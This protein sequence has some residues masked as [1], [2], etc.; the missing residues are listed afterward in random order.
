MPDIPLFDDW[1]RSITP[2]SPRERVHKIAAQV[3][4]PADLA[5]DYL[6]V[7][8]VESGHRTDVRDSPKGAKGFGQVMPDRPGATTRTVDG[9]RYDLRNPDENV[10]AGLRL[11]QAGG[12]DPV[13]RRLEYFG[14]AGARRQYER[15]GRI[16]NI[17]DGN[18]TAEQY[19]RATGGYSQELTPQ[20]SISRFDDWAKSQQSQPPEQVSP[21]TAK[22]RPTP[23]PS[24]P[25]TRPAYRTPFA[26]APPSQQI[27]IRQGVQDFERP[28]MRSPTG[29]GAILLRQYGQARGIDN[30]QRQRE[31]ATRQQVEQEY[32][33]RRG[34]YGGPTP[35]GILH[36]FANPVDSLLGLARSDEENIARET[37]E[38][39]RQ[40]QVAAQPEVESI[41]RE[42]GQMSAPV[43]SIAAPLIGRG[44][45]GLLKVAGGI[46]SVFGI[47]P[48]RLSDWANKRGEIIE[49]ASALP[50]LADERNLSS[51]VTGETQLKEVERGIPEKVATGLADL[52]VG[53][54]QIILLKRA[55]RLPFNQLLA[56][57]AAAKSSNAPLDQQLGKAAEG[58]ALGTAL[59]SHLGR[60][61]S[62]AL[63]GVPTA[64][65]SGYEVAQGRTSPLDAAIQTGIQAGAGAILGGS[66]RKP[67][68]TQPRMVE[69]TPAERRTAQI[70]ATEADREAIRGELRL[71]ERPHEQAFRERQAAREASSEAPH[72]S[73]RQPRR[74]RGEGKGQFKRGKPVPTEEPIPIEQSNVPAE[75]PALPT[76][77]PATEAVP[78]A[79]E[80]V[81][82]SSLPGESITTPITEVSQPAVTGFTTSQGSAYTVSGQSTQR[83]KTPHVGHDPG[84]IGLKPPSEKT[85]YLDED[86]AREVG[87]WN[88]LNASGKRIAIRGDEVLL[89]S[90]NPKTNQRGLD[91]RFKFTTDPAVGKSPLELRERS[92]S[93]GQR[94]ME[95]YR[96]NHPGTPIR[97]IQRAGQPEAATIRPRPTIPAVTPAPELT[98]EQ[99]LRV[100]HD[101]LSTPEFRE[102]ILGESVGGNAGEG[103]A[104][105]NAAIDKQGKVV[106]LGNIQDFPQ[107]VRDKLDRGEYFPASFI[108]R[109]ALT[110]EPAVERV[111]LPSPTPNQPRQVASDWHVDFEDPSRSTGNAPPEFQEMSRARQS[112][113]APVTETRPRPTA[114]KDAAMQADR[115]ELGLPELE[116]LPRVSAPEVLTE[117]QQRNSANPRATD[118]LVEQAL[119]GKKNFTNVETMQVNLRAQEV[120]NRLNAINDEAF[121]ETDPSRLSDLRAESD[122]LLTEFDRISTAQD[123]AGAEWSRAGTARQRAIAE[124]Y[125]L[126]GLIARAKKVKGRDLTPEE[127][128]HYEQQA[129]R[130]TELE[131]QLN[132]A[133]SRVDDKRFQRE[134]DKLA[135]SRRRGDMREQLDT[136]YA[137]LLTEFKQARA[138]TRNVQAS[139]LAGLDP[140][141]KLTRI[142]LR[143]ARNRVLAGANNAAQLVEGIYNDL[144]DA[145]PGATERDIRDAISGY[146]LTPKTQRSNLQ[147]QLAALKSE[148]QSLSK[149]EDI[150]G[151]IRS[152]RVEGPRLG[153]AIGR[154]EGPQLGPRQGPRPREGW[155]R[156]AEGPRLTETTERKQGPR[157]REGW[158]RIEGPRLSEA[159]GRKEG[160]RQRPEGP[161]K[162]LFTRNETR[163]RQITEQIADLERRIDEQD[164]TPRP[165]QQPLPYTKE[166]Q[167]LEEQLQHTK[168]KFELEM[169]RASPGHWLRQLSG[170]RKSW[171]LSGLS[172]QA[173]NIGGTGAYQIF[174]EV[175]R[176]P[177]VIAD[178]AIAPFTNRRTVTANPVAMLDSVVH[179]ATVGLSEAGQI[180]RKGATREQLERHQF[181]EIDTGVKVIDFTSNLVFRFMSASDRV[182]YQYAHQRNLS[183][184]ARVQ[185]LNEGAG[186]VRARTKELVA[187]PP[188]ELDAAAKHDALVST[189]NNNNLLSNAIKRARAQMGPTANFAIDM[190][191]PFDRTPTNVIARIIEA[192][193]VGAGRAAYGLAKAA[194]TK[195]LTA[196]EQ[197]QFAQTL[198]RATAGTALM[199]LGWTLADKLLDVEKYQVFLNV[200]NQRIDLASISPVGNLLALGARLR[201]DYEKGSVT[202]AV[203]TVGGV[204]LQQPLLKSTTEAV[205]TL[206]DPE[207]SLTRTGARLASSFIPMGGL[208]RDVG[209]LID[210]EERRA[211]TFKEQVQ[212]NVPGLRQRLPV[213][214]RARRRLQ[215]SS[216][217][218]E[219]GARP[220]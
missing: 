212:Q 86:A 117:A 37:Q 154:K 76:A 206:S 49:T 145:L 217:R 79:S 163:A 203:K 91:G 44:G 19:V 168:N 16:P 25:A 75:Q 200:G 214:P 202:G 153:D 158:R 123:K 17:S 192:S 159:Q 143:M 53:L 114:P 57:E 41:R 72:Y 45:G 205:E 61:A 84:D 85:I 138:E 147:A 90:L 162:R 175:A 160:P 140:E 100:N 40:Q 54:G 70:E 128:T 155:K 216:G 13:A 14:G 18:M 69:E 15:T 111:I 219:A 7:A 179:A 116:Q 28:P 68:E 190:V 177:A 204:P 139:G 201:K 171:M 10:E 22:P 124:D 170:V 97:E 173:K 210:P 23:A 62:A 39:V 191:M 199:A 74:V 157:E 135:R 87:I 9:R 134:I 110:N 193:P 211:V 52:G 161:P 20:Q 198:G 102:R 172:T 169:E 27:A 21:P 151:G 181:S 150:A 94:G 105:V 118:T 4:I 126:V 207:R 146:S 92:A 34:P 136:E 3:D 66:R 33:A 58:Y 71:A 165:K 6:R 104:A 129:S 220:Q 31:E 108:V 180:I 189:F 51:L 148:L 42:Y 47:A 64:A 99:V 112:V 131:S 164:F 80:T 195:S 24:T 132:L 144:R 30:L 119:N 46:A 38:R 156:G 107:E 127:R 73:N 166:V 120:K 196:A 218:P 88:T 36:L 121:K 213:K 89:T 2:R 82:P 65:Q 115:A 137:Q 56:L 96:W 63:F 152:P 113:T 95:G 149:S 185:A 48:N 125:S 130:I 176:L 186:N 59:E 188:E 184:R 5:D 174:D 141:G 142:V 1:V 93:M 78:F 109:D 183:D 26:P 197:R 50:P 187:N 178:A 77:E 215:R 101:L 8:R 209:K 133:R 103:R 55:T 32:R 167:R 29:R 43:R 194:I 98:P 12:S 106:R 81:F 122:T 182:F 11:F 35:S 60:G 83:T 67:I 208:V